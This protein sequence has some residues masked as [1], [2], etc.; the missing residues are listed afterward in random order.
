MSALKIVILTQEDCAFCQEAKTL[1]DRLAVD[2]PLAISTLS[3][4]SREG[5][6]LAARTGVLFPPGI[7]IGEEVLCYGR[8]SE[9]RLRREFERRRLAR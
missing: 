7:L 8:P 4:E 5:Q 2:Y 9:K 6:D 1:L 3:L